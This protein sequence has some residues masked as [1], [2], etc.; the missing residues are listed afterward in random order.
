MWEEIDASFMSEESTHEES[1]GIVVHKHSPS[2]RSERKH[3]V[4]F[5]YA[6]VFRLG[7]SMCVDTLSMF[8]CF[9]RRWALPVCTCTC[10][11]CQSV[12]A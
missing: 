7:L 9:V 6:I 1:D 5:V 10:A 4:F 11:F 12:C 2:F 8:V 3:L